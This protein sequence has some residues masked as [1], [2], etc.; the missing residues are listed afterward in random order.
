MEP[1]LE[2]A[3]RSEARA[4]CVD[5]YTDYL[6]YRYLAEKER[7]DFKRI[8]EEMAE[9]E[10]RHYEFWKSVVGEECKAG[11]PGW[12]L[13]LIRISRMLF[14]LTFTIKLLEMH[15]KEVIES[16]KRFLPRLSG[17][18]RRRLEEIIADEETHEKSLLSRLNEGIV[19][20]MGFIALGLADAIVEITGVHAGFLGATTTTLVAG[21]A[22]LIVGL[23]AAI[24]MAAAAY[25]QAKHEGNE[26]PVTSALVTGIA[27]IFAVIVLALPYFA[28]H[29][30]ILAFAVSVAL[31]VVLVVGFTFY[32]AVINE[33][34]FRR[35]VMENLAVL[36][37][38]A[39]AAYI[40]GDVLGRI[41]GIQEIFG[42]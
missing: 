5:E 9:Q 38:T 12:K 26:N 19:R 21:I 7:G 25:L 8:L 29:S 23:S 13:R 4:F 16:Y 35:E 15:E 37:G 42:A 24:S 30:N 6:I 41:F 10:L 28:T 20:Y 39:A 34:N 2:E 27:Y 18:A 11:V 1:R 33:S 17:D 31:A 36:F 14:G 32:S 22:G 40:F 3:A